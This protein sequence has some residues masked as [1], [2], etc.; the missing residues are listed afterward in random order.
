MQLCGVLVPAGSVVMRNVLCWHG[1]T[2]NLSDEVRALPNAEFLAPWCVQTCHFLLWQLSTFAYR[3]ISM[4]G[5][6]SLCAILCRGN[7]M[8]KC[9]IMA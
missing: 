3:E 9:L 1:G 2:P 5:I 6:G 7:F 4:P 8:K